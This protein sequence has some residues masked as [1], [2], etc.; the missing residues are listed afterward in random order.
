MPSFRNSLGSYVRISLGALAA[1]ML[2]S[3]PC[4]VPARA[5]ELL[6]ETVPDP[7]WD[8]AFDRSEGWIGGDAIYSTPL[9][10][11]DVLWLFADTYIG[12][13]NDQRSNEI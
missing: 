3:D 1:A 11:G 2:L 4:L 5:D 9:P 10:G 13:L 8:A 12:C 6:T 7:G